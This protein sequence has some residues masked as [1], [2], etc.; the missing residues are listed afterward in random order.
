MTRLGDGPFFQSLRCLNL[1]C[2]A[3]RMCL[4]VLVDKKCV[5]V[6]IFRRLIINEE[7]GASLLSVDRYEDQASMFLEFGLP[8][9]EKRSY[10]LLDPC[11][12][13]KCELK[14]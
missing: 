14:F 4:S 8:I 1:R 11:I 2:L 7:T 12:G 6:D 5:T 3:L 13:W 10:R 9:Y